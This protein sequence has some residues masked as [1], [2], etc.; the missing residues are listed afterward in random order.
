MELMKVRE[1]ESRKMYS[2]EEESERGSRRKEN[3]LKGSEKNVR[4]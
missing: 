4:R 2:Y 3:T 1:R